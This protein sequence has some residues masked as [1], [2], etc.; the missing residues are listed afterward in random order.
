MKNPINP[1]D[2]TYQTTLNNILTFSGITL[3]KGIISNLKIK[4]SQEDTGISFK[5]TD[6]KSHNI[7][8]AHYSNVA[9]TNLC[10]KLSNNKENA[11]TWRCVK[12][13][14]PQGR[15]VFSSYFLVSTSRQSFF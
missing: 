2:Y 4:P 12:T 7:V 5:R 6:A 15:A 13:S 9:E 11:Q 1:V 10:T 3:H 8:K 14:V